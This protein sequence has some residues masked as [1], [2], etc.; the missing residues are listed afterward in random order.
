[1]MDRTD[2]HYRYMMRCITRHTLLYTEMVNMNAVL[3]GDRV[4]LLGFDARER[5]LSLQLGGDDP[6]LLAECAAIAE[7]LGYDEVN[8]NVGCP[9]ARV[10]SGNFGACLMRTP[11][12]VAACVAAMRARVAVP[13]TV[14]CRIGVDDHDQY[15]DLARFADAV[16]AAGADRL[17]VHAR[18]AWL[19]GLSP[20]QNRTVPPLRYEDVYRLKRAHPDWPIEI[21]GGV[22]TLDDVQAHLTQVDAVMIGRAAYEQPML[23]ATVDQRFFG[24][25]RP[26][27]TRAEVAQQ[28]AEY[29]AR[30]AGPEWKMTRITRHLVNLFRGVAG[31][32]VWRQEL[33]CRSVG[34][35]APASVITD[36]LRQLPSASAAAGP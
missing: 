27:V 22:L 23:F 7:D 19:Q 1:M 34:S 31:A 32:R 26:V 17:S 3:R 21:N 12:T 8:L 18:K 9:S 14:K 28:M 30:W 33:T 10:Q 35:G 29:A 24:S 4:R 5:P 6:T 13:V 15:E 11:D 16:K 20:K 36:A 25:Q 2:R